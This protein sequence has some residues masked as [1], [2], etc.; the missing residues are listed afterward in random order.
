[1]NKEE[2][3]RR[4]IA[5]FLLFFALTILSTRELMISRGVITN[6][7]WAVAPYAS[8]MRHAFVNIFYLWRNSY[9]GFDI[10]SINFGLGLWLVL[11][12]PSFL[13][14]DGEILTKYIV[15]FSILLSG[16]FFYYTC[17]SLKKS[18][19][20]SIL[21]AIFYMFTPW[22]FNRVVAGDFYLGIMGYPLLPLSFLFFVKSTICCGG[23]PKIKYLLLASL[24][25]FFVGILGVVICIVL[26]ALYSIVSIVCSA[27]PQKSLH[28]YISSLSIVC[29]LALVLY[30]YWIIPFFLFQGN[31]GIPLNLIDLIVRSRN[32][33]LLNVIRLIGQVLPFY[34]D[35]VK[36]FPWWTVMS[37]LP[38]F[39][40]WLGLLI[41][42]KDKNVIIFSLLAIFFIYL[43]KGNNPPLG[44]IYEWAYLNV[45]F[46]QA[47]RDPYKL[48]MLVSFAYSFLLCETIQGLNTRLHSFFLNKRHPL[49]LAKLSRQSLRKSFS[50]ILALIIFSIISINALPFLSGGFSRNLKL[51]NFPVEY[52]T[53][54]EWLE[55][56]DGDFRVFWLPFDPRIQYDW[57]P[58]GQADLMAQY[59]V[60]PHF[61]PLLGNSPDERGRFSNLVVMTLCD[62]RTNFLGKLLGMANVKYVVFRDDA[63]SYD[64][65]HLLG[66]HKFSREQ[67]KYAIQH[68]N[69]L[70]LV[71]KEGAL[72]VYQN[73]YNMPHLF[74]TSSASLI[75]G[76]YSSLISLSYIDNFS[77]KD[78]AV[79]FANQVAS[80]D[81]L[82]HM[83]TVIIQ[84]NELYDLVFMLLPAH[85][86]VDVAR[87]VYP[88]YSP[89]DHWTALHYYWGYYYWPYLD[90]INECA[91]TRGK[92]VLRIP[93]QVNSSGNYDIW[94]KSFISPK[95]G[96][97]DVVID[98]NFT[99]KM[100]TRAVNEK[101][102]MWTA[103]G[104]LALASGE[105]TIA[106]KNIEGEQVIAAIVIAPPKSISDAMDAVL[107]SLQDKN[108]ILVF[109]LEKVATNF[110]KV[111]GWDE[112][113]GDIR[114][115]YESGGLA[116]YSFTTD[117][118]VA[119]FTVSGNSWDW[120]CYTFDLPIPIPT[121]KYPFFKYKIRGTL[122]ARYQFGFYDG[123]EWHS[124]P[125]PYWRFSDT[126]A[127]WT[128]VTLPLQEIVGSGKVISKL[129]IY[130]QTSD[131]KPAS[132]LYDEIEFFGLKQLPSRK[133]G[134]GASLGSA[135]QLDENTELTFSVFIPKSGKYEIYLRAKGTKFDA[136]SCTLTFSIENERKQIDISGIDFGWYKIGEI[137]LIRGNYNLS[138]TVGEKS[139]VYLD[140]LLINSIEPTKAGLMENIDFSYQMISPTEYKIHARTKKPFF[141]VLSEAYS[142]YWRA[143][144][145]GEEVKPMVA[146]SFAN[147]FLINETGDLEITLYFIKQK[148][149]EYGLW[150]SI[151][152]FVIMATYIVAEELLEMRKKLKKKGK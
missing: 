2:V 145:N 106:F 152:T 96:L 120:R 92:A 134:S 119:N 113:F 13:G 105:H 109:E 14:V 95:G 46:F 73:N 90:S 41:R 17:V 11:G 69:G 78:S 135:L 138:I 132:I 79:F 111:I 108:L 49:T 125:S 124:F 75:A 7:D 8:Q 67:L 130:A 94:V 70:E 1:M 43:G 33:Q 98:N 103:L 107:Q 37:F 38:V 114:G 45:P 88:Y 4:H 146:Y 81:V 133:T 149:Y 36:A 115:W 3:I 54:N 58:H 84:D 16:V 62:N 9:G 121:D 34:S 126:P 127:S 99:L 32:A 104:T 56:Q 147:A 141:L 20:A 136:P 128:E 66:L 80:Q 83:D 61:G 100:D 102:F 29:C 28:T 68:Q 142:E 151:S 110:D 23:K 19:A 30:S 89:D 18:Y 129:A 6:H 63:E 85:Y 131:G 47:F 97:I 48:V 82:E 42:P 21:A 57:A 116:E 140:A 144:V 150:I 64:W 52:S 40:V 39:F 137:S 44:Q 77:F 117:G 76:G 143:Y 26:F 27:E 60:K 87:Y 24:P 112:K 122:N 55:N 74:A 65:Y 53:I 5:P 86:K 25:L 72:T 50:V 139:E 31:T 118:N 15:I 22:I 10:S 51:S 101:G 59:S 12:P 91:F 35:S 93:F 123:S 71:K 148:Y